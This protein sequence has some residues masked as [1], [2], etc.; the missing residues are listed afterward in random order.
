MCQWLLFTD[1]QRGCG[2]LSISDI[3]LLVSFLGVR[4]R[5]VVHLFY[6][7]YDIMY[8]IMYDVMYNV[9]YD[10]VQNLWFYIVSGDVITK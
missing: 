3:Y 2:K 4:G 6:V 10:I 7:M 8:Y 5:E 1:W 9:M